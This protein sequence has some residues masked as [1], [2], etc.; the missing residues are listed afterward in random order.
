MG[1]GKDKF[2]PLKREV[3]R[4]RDRAPII[5]CFTYLNIGTF[6]YGFLPLEVIISSIKNRL[7]DLMGSFLVS[8]NRHQDAFDLGVSEAD[9]IIA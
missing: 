2:F 9:G 1:S 6:A 5:G 7:E 8:F 4:L 3:T